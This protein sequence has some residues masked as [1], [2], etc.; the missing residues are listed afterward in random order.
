[1]AMCWPPWTL[2]SSY[3]MKVVAIILGENEAP[4][5]PLTVE[6]SSA[7][8]LRSLKH[9]WDLYQRTSDRSLAVAIYNALNIR[10]LD[11]L[12]K[13]TKEQQID[14]MAMVTSG[15][16]LNYEGDE[17]DWDDMDEGIYMDDP[18]DLHA[19]VKWIDVHNNSNDYAGVYSNSY[20]VTKN[21]YVTIA[22]GKWLK[23]I[24]VKFEYNIDSPAS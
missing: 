23:S 2:L 19:I 9:A 20:L 13:K 18:N 10:L 8:V 11:E 21:R 24:G 1:M 12:L 15:D 16:I 5:W 3:V 22:I 17:N 6:Y 4:T 14:T 7:I